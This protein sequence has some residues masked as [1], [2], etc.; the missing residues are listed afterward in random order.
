[1][2]HA[3]ASSYVNCNRPERLTNMEILLLRDFVE[4]RLSQVL[5]ANAILDT[6]EENENEKIKLTKGYNESAHRMNYTSAPSIYAIRA[7]DRVKVGYTT[8]PVRRLKE[9]KL[10]HV[11][12]EYA[13]LASGTRDDEFALHKI[14]EPFH[15][16]GEWYV[17]SPEMQKVLDSFVEAK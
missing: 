5:R 10:H 7:F 15:L 1:M 4:K 8:N 12:A 2:S 16:T 13:M 17:Y 11:E 6:I 3:R 9:Y 14:L